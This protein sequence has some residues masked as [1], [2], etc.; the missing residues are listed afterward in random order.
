MGKPTC[1]TEFEEQAF[2][3]EWSRMMAETGQDPRLALLHGDSSGVRVPIGCAVKM[4]RAGSIKGFPDLFLP[5]GQRYPVQY[6]GLFLELKRLVGGTVSPE[7]Q[8]IHDA[9]REQ[10]YRVVV[11]KGADAAIREIKAYL[12]MP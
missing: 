4:R 9:L 10:G 12:G 11:V 3:I 1:P 2:V 5:V 7:Q 8:A 6:H